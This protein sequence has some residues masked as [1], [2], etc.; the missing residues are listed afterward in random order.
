M[1]S[2]YPIICWINSASETT[3]STAQ[4][5]VFSPFLFKGMFFQWKKAYSVLYPGALLDVFSLKTQIRGHQRAF[6][7]PFR[8]TFFIIPQPIVLWLPNSDSTEWFCFVL[9]ESCCWL[10]KNASKTSLLTSISGHGKFAHLGNAVSQWMSC[11]YSAVLRMERLEP[12]QQQ[13]R[14]SAQCPS[15]TPAKQQQLCSPFLWWRPR[16]QA[17]SKLAGWACQRPLGCE[18]LLLCQC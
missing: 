13:D 9:L 18:R 11:H 3:L 1:G 8:W 14:S 7:D 15:L 16:F 17:G 5:F 12:L 4:F 10:R 2:I 6:L